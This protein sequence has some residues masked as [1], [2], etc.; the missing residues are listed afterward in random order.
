MLR[1]AIAVVAA[2]GLIV[3]AIY[4]IGGWVMRWTIRAETFHRD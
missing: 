3:T 4:V 2:L 1:I